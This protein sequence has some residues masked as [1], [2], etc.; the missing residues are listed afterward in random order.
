MSVAKGGAGS[1]PETRDLPHPTG[2]TQQLGVRSLGDTE[3]NCSSGTPW[4]D[5]L[6]FQQ[7]LGPGHVWNCGFSY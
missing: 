1:T 7:G 3:D 4:D 2:S 6:P 5:G